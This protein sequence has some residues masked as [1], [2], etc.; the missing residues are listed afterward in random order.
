MTYIKN[1]S[2]GSSEFD[3]LVAL[4]EHVKNNYERLPS[5]E[6]DTFLK[7][8]TKIKD[9]WNIKI[10]NFDRVNRYTPVDFHSEKN[11]F[12]FIMRWT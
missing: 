5:D 12:W 6:R 7:I 9:Q 4:I 1:I 10:G 8:K 11:Y 3:G 2:K